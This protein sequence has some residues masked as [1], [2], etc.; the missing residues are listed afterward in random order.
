MSVQ[1]E[2]SVIGKT[3]TDRKLS[4]R[5]KLEESARPTELVV[6]LRNEATR[7]FHFHA[8]GVAGRA[9]L[10]HGSNNT[11]RGSDQRRCKRKDKR[12]G[13]QTHRCYRTGDVAGGCAGHVG[14]PHHSCRPRF[15]GGRFERD[16]ELR[17]FLVV[18][19]HPAAPDAPPNPGVSIFS[20][21]FYDG[22][23]YTYVHTGDP[24]GHDSNDN[25]AFSD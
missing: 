10:R 16:R 24:L 22:S 5:V 19:A 9:R 13:P 17:P 2:S 11:S 15:V 23:D 14:H 3:S 25:E 18:K 1:H 6:E 7:R 20:E 12:H 4:V 21:V 8:P